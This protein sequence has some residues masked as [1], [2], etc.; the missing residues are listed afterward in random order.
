MVLSNEVDG[1]DNDLGATQSGRLELGPG[2]HDEGVSYFPAVASPLQPS[3]LVRRQE[4]LSF[5][6]HFICGPTGSSL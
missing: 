3:D 4:I 2:Y 1:A 6:C 5:L